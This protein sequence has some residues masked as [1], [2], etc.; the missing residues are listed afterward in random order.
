MS[1]L[2]FP[3]REACIR[4]APPTV[5]TS[6]QTRRDRRDSIRRRRPQGSCLVQSDGGGSRE[7]RRVQRTSRISEGSR[8]QHAPFRPTKQIG[9]HR[10]SRLSVLIVTELAAG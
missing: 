5:L 7:P 8:L 3:G 1:F 4:V 10:T 2:P 6:S 9:L